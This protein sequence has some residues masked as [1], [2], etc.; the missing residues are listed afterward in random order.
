VSVVAK[1]GLWADGLDTGIF[2]LGAER[3]MEL[4]E[5]LEDVEAVIV[6]AH[7]R[8]LVSSGL[9]NRVRLS[10]GVSQ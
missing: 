9:R 1:E 3:G 8:V 7:G 4:V 5:Q 6:D 10:S 2:V